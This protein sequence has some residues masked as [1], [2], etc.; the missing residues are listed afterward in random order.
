[1]KL[2]DIF[3]RPTIRERRFAN[4]E[5]IPA[6]TF[7]DPGA[8]EYTFKPSDATL[9]DSWNGGGGYTAAVLTWT[10]ERTGVV[11]LVAPL[12]GDSNT[13][14]SI[15]AGTRPDIDYPTASTPED[16][17]IP[18][19]IYLSGWTAGQGQQRPIS[20]MR[21]HAGRTYTFVAYDWTDTGP[22]HS[23]DLSELIRQLSLLGGFRAV[24]PQHAPFQY[25][26]T[27][28]GLEARHLPAFACLDQSASG[29]FRYADGPI[30]NEGFYLP[31][32]PDITLKFEQAADF[33]GSPSGFA[34]DDYQKAI[35]ADEWGI[36]EGLLTIRADTSGTQAGDLDD[37]PT[38]LLPYTGRG[39]PEMF[40]ALPTAPND[41]VGI[42]QSI[43]VGPRPLGPDGGFGIGIEFVA[44][45]AD[46]SQNFT[47]IIGDGTKGRLSAQLTLSRVGDLTD[48]ALGA[49]LG[50]GL[51]DL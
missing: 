12:G 20:T 28:D 26:Q 33:N 43:P 47:D 2:K 11:T 34:W 48:A 45:K 31:L 27:A 32:Y 4:A 29:T 39:S 22:G 51:R 50:S 19:G 37:A 21:L 36:Y 7:G 23:I 24:A 5:V 8:L 17:D 30:E 16:A 49:L 41:Y 6:V 9:D 35:V 42:V 15:Y 25:V 1:M 46:R 10:P 3:A 44:W 38:T 40:I 18:D 14:V 13:Q